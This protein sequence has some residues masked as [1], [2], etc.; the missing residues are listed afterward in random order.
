MLCPVSPPPL[1]LRR[2]KGDRALLTSAV[3]VVD[4]TLVCMCVS[5]YCSFVEIIVLGLR[6]LAPFQLQKIHAPFLEFDC[7]DR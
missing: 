6:D 5:F 2:I 1:S 7:G 3:A 4:W